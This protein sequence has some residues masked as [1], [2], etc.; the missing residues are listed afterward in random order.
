[1]TLAERCF[2]RVSAED[3][4]FSTIH[5]ILTGTSLDNCLDDG[6][7]WRVVDTGVDEYDGSIE[8]ILKQGSLPLTRQE[9]DKILKLGF[10][11]IWESN[12][13]CGRQWT[14]LYGPNQCQP[15]KPSDEGPLQI[16]KLRQ[17]IKQLEE[18]VK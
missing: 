9:V 1:M 10:G 6:F 2:D 4:L 8:V 11:Q 7:E 14:K 18:G 3:E 17:R 12:G 5:G 16:Q 13:E 15:R